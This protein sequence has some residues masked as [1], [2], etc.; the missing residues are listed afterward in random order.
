MLYFDCYLL[1]YKRRKTDS[2]VNTCLIPS[3]VIK[4]NIILI[5]TNLSIGMGCF[6]TMA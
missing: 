6:P 2:K 5:L 3:V 1:Q 4:P